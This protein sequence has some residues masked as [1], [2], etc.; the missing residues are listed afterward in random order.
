MWDMCQLCDGSWVT[1]DVPFPSLDDITEW[2]G[3]KIN[4]E[5]AAAE[6][7]GRSREILRAANKE[8]RH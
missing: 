8:G 6:D 4:E 5:A 7:C 3:M 1:K 2:T